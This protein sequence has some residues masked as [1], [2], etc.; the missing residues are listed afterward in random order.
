MFVNICMIEHIWRT[1]GLANITLG[2]QKTNEH[3]NVGMVIY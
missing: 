1:L 2:V 3:D